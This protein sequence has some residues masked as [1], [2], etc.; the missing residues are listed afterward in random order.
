MMNTFEKGTKIKL[1]SGD[2]VE[3]VKKLGDGGQGI[4][5]FVNYKKKPYALKWYY[6]NKLKNAQQFKENIVNNIKQGPPT[7]AFIWPQMITKNQDDSFGY[8]MDLRPIEYEDFSR[9]L[10]AKVKF[11]SVSAVVNAALNIVNGFR[12][13]HRCGYSYQDIN[14]GNFFINPE[15]GEV[16][17]C[18]NDNVAQYGDNL[19]IAGKCRYM[20]PEVV[21]GEKHPSVHTDRYSLAVTLFLLLFVSHPLEG[22]RTTCPCMTE[23]LEKKFYGSEPVFI[24]DPEN[25][26]NRPVR[27]IHNNAIKLWPIYPRYIQEAFEKSFGEGLKKENARLTET[28]WQKLFLRLRDETITCGCGSE[29][30]VDSEADA[31]QCMGCG[32]TIQTPLFLKVKNNQVALYPKSKLYKCHTNIDSDDFKEEMGEVIQSKSNPGLW[33]LRNSSNTTWYMTTPDGKQKDVRPG[34]V[35]Q[36]LRGIMIDFGKNR[37]EII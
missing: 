3:V 8:L 1:E 34:G 19:G 25:D 33:G 31:I 30:F 9:F 28:Q 12:E 4:V 11:S 13:L 15:S 14:D 17:I 35:V 20:A 22:S 37:G 24:F 5:Y 23:S 21:L 27:G 2:S 36:I 32:K 18:D 6:P 10:T 16:L 26:T 7:E 29:V